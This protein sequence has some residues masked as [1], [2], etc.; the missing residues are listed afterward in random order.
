MSTYQKVIFLL[1]RHQAGCQIRQTKVI[2]WISLFPRVETSA[3]P[4]C[5]ITWEQWQQL[6][7]TMGMNYIRHHQAYTT[8]LHATATILESSNAKV[9]FLEAVIYFY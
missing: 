3:T 9:F 8:A 5:H 2:V 6:S 4:Y 1:Q 7:V